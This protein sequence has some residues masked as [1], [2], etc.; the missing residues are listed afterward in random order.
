M[1]MIKRLTTILFTIM[2]V[3]T[4]TTMVFAE[5]NPT[6][7][8]STTDKGTITITNAIKN[9]EY[10][11]YKIFDLESYSGTNYSYKVV[12]EWKDFFTGGLKEAI[13]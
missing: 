3:L 4:T 8:S 13:I 11:V 12:P 7:G 1:K 5:G 10:K 9:Q 2:M 6:A